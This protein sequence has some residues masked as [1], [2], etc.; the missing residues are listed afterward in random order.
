MAD[1]SLPGESPRRCLC[2][3]DR[4]GPIF[5]PFE[6]P[7]APTPQDEVIDLTKKDIFILRRPQ[8]GRLEGREDGLHLPCGLLGML[9]TIGTRQ[10]RGC[11]RTKQTE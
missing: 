10:A 4:L 7:S 1:S 8:S 5:R 3:G 9:G 2:A 6:T 11:D